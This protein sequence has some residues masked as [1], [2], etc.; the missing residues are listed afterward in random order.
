MLSTMANWLFGCS[1]R[2]TSFPITIR[3]GRGRQRL[4]GMETYIVC[5]DC[6]QH[7]AYD[8]DQMKVAPPAVAAESPL[9]EGGARFRALFPDLFQRRPLLILGIGP[10]ARTDA[11]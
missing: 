9:G 6:G 7:L 8:W 5:L 10:R 1:H 2:R 3:D 11:P 4:K